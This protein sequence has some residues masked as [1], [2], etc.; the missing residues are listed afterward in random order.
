MNPRRDEAVSAEKVRGLRSAYHAQAQPLDPGNRPGPVARPQLRIRRLGI[1]RLRSEPK[2]PG[3]GKREGRVT[4]V[5]SPPSPASGGVTQRHVPTIAAVRG[6]VVPG[7]VAS[8]AR[9]RERRAGASTSRSR[10]RRRRSVVSR[11]AAGRSEKT[12]P[13]TYRRYKAHSTEPR[14]HPTPGPGPE[15][16][17][18][19]VRPRTRVRSAQP[20]RSVRSAPHRRVRSPQP[21]RSPNRAAPSGLL[22]RRPLRPEQR[23]GGV[24]RVSR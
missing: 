5:T 17:K 1:S 18:R 8:A 14:D 24:E 4:A 15:P 10:V 13:L 21:V 3:G 2:R 23:V 16:R 9:S 7:A 22:R 6:Q 20:V 19:T 12:I 11:P